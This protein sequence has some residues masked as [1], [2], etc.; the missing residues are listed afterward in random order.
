MGVQ[1]CKRAV[2]AVLDLRGRDNRTSAGIGAFTCTTVA[3]PRPCRDG[4]VQA[5]SQACQTR[6]RYSLVRVSISIMS[7]WATK[8]GTMIS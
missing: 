3:P 2:G 8:I 7:S 6:L 4:G 5:A 1:Q